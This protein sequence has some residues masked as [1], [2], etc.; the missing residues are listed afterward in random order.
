MSDQPE[1]I[2]HIRDLLFSSKVTATAR[3]QGVPV[4]VKRNLEDVAGRVLIVDLNAEGALERAVAW[5][6]CTGGSVIGFLAHVAGDQI[7][8]AKAIGI[9]RVMSNGSFSANL[10]AIL[11]EL[12]R[13]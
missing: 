1:I 10:P 7:A 4:Q 3:A 6:S 8:A 5:K 11:A 13:A 9:D 12:H 2:V